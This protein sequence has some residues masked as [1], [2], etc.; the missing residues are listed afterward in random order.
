M[1]VT[2]DTSVLVDFFTRKHSER[3]TIA[4]ELLKVVKGKP[5]FCPRL[6]LAEI[7]GVLARYN[8]ELADLGYNFVI[9]NFNLINENE[10]FDIVLEV[11]KNTGCRAIDSYLIATAKL[12]D[13]ILITNDKVMNENAK[14]FGIESYYL[15]EDFDKV[16]DKIKNPR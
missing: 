4:K 14:K 9:K 11:C 1:G 16:L 2:I 13:S 6:I 10:I 8:V 12:T 15:L 7:L 3:Y 5:V